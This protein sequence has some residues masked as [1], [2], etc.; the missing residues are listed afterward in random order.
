M[1][2]SKVQIKEFQS[3]QNSTLV[4]IGDVTC[5][6]GKNETGQTAVLQALYRLNPINEADGFIDVTDVCPRRAVVI[7]R[8]DV[9]AKRRMHAD[10]ISATCSLESDGAT[11][12]EEMLGPACLKD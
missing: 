8:N 7:G 11:A 1:R 9:A 4:E 12:V 3:I 2:L 5:L 6:L 10:V